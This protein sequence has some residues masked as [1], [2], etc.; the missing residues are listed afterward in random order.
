MD[1]LA[2][3]TTAMLAFAG[4]SF[5]LAP[6]V[7]LGFSGIFSTSAMYGGVPH[8]PGYPLWTCYAWAF[9]KLLPFGDM[10][11]RVAV[12]SAAATALACGLIAWLVAKESEALLQQPASRQKFSA[13]EQA[14]TQLISGC[15]AGLVFGFSGS[16]W[17]RA[18]IADV[19]PLTL[20]LLVLFLGLMRRWIHSPQ[21]RHFLFAAFLVFGAGADE[22]SC[23]SRTGSGHSRSHSRG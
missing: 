16:V 14:W 20:L 19:W 8:P 10:A 15:G 6:G 1:W 5:S 7:T 21:R 3:V 9:T 2:L 4:Y 18:V 22:Q 11:W 17:Q 12:S 23:T 13:A